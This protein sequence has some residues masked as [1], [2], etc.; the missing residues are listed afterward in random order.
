MTEREEQAKA[1]AAMI[2]TDIQSAAGRMQPGETLQLL[3]SYDLFLELRFHSESVEG[4]DG[5]PMYFG[6]ARVFINTAERT[7]ALT[8]TVLIGTAHRELEGII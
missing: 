3:L 5:A 4:D 1:F 7:G 8:Y 6:D 2:E